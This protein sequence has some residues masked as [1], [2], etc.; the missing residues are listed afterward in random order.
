M[1]RFNKLNEKRW[2]GFLAALP[3]EYDSVKAQ[4]VSN[5]RISSLQE[6]FSRILRTEICSPALPSDHMSSALVGRNIGES[7]K[8]QYKNS[9]PSDKPRGPSSGGVV[10]YYCSKHGHAIRDCKKRH[11][12]NQR[13]PSA[14]ASSTNEASNQSLQFTEE[15][16]VKFNLYQES[17]KSPSTLITAITESGTPNKC[18]VSSLSFEW[19]IDSRTIDHMTGN[20]SLFSNFQSQPSTFIATLAN[21]SQPCVHRSRTIFATPFIPLSSILSLPNFSSNLMSVSKL[22]RA[23]KCYI[24]FFLDFCLF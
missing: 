8:Q 16:L 11:S 17:L 20:S 22:T 18:L 1:L 14:H 19:V 24:S 6:T 12:R 13:S 5:P 7:E 15:E 4:I 2:Q 23:R 10:S 3:S 21:G 9:G